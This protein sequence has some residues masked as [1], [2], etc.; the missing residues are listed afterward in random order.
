[1]GSNP[2]GYV[3]PQPDPFPSPPCELLQPRGPV[4]CLPPAEVG[5]SA[6]SHGQ[7]LPGGLRS[8]HQS[9]PD[10]M[11]PPEHHPPKARVWI[12]AYIRAPAVA[13]TLTSHQ[14]TLPLLDF[15][16]P[17]FPEVFENSG[18]PFEILGRTLSQLE[19][20]LESV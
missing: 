18:I 1:M 20:P 4:F 16:A 12:R 13:K 2:Q 15:P 10:V 9:G 5:W 11:C 7:A 3:V 6:T 8:W 14:A 19:G 17:S